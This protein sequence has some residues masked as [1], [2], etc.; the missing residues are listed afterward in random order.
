MPDNRMG[1]DPVIDIPRAP[2]RNDPDFGVQRMLDGHR[3]PG[4]GNN[5][6]LAEDELRNIHH[7]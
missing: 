7:P 6:A 5:T 1:D 4:E 2:I 3:H